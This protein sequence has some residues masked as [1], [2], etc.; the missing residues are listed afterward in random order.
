MMNQNS[1]LVTLG[2]PIYN[3][4]LW[5]NQAIKTLVA[6]D[7]PNTQILLIDDCSSDDSWNICQEYSKE[8]AN[9]TIERNNK[10]IG[11]IANFK[12]VLSKAEGKYFVWC[13][14]DDYWEKDFTSL[15][16]PRLEGDSDSVIAMGRTVIHSD[17]KQPYEVTILPKSNS[18]FNSYFSQAFWLMYPFYKKQFIKNNLFLHG[19]INTQILKDAN[20]S[21]PGDM[22]V[23]RH[24]L[25]QL[26]LSGKFLFVDQILYH[27][28]V[29]KD[30]SRRVHD[31][32]SKNQSHWYYPLKGVFQMIY[33]VF[34]LKTIPKY[35]KLY[36]IPLSAVCIYVWLISSFKITLERL[37]PK[38]VYGCLKNFNNKY[39]G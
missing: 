39:F 14:Q 37:L 25:I 24:F 32:I 38:K 6:Q 36:I 2:M 9:I 29:H 18:N 15:L 4:A 28:R 16:V 23:D 17:D 20:D 11:A 7:Y 12:K 19:L 13:S 3:G 5:L 26:A 1:P 27:R 21:F 35:K 31:L 8:H 30:N 10:N 33:S 22:L 34:Y